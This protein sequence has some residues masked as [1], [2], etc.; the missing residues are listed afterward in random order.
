M[1]K[2]GAFAIDTEWMV[3]MGIALGIGIMVFLGIMI[4][5]GRLGNPGDFLRHLLRFG[6]GG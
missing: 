2:R 3:W 6:G 4:A 5:T 1:K